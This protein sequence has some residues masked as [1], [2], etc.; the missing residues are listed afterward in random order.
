[1]PIEDEKLYEE[2]GRTWRHFA[3]WREKAFAGYLTALAALAIGFSHNRS[4]PVRAGVFA[5]AILVSTV[6]W[7]IDFRNL[8]LMHACQRAAGPLERE[9]GWYAELNRVRDRKS[10]LTHGLAINLLVV[11][12]GVASVL[13]ISICIFRWWSDGS[14]VWPSWPFLVLLVVGVGVLAI[15][16]HLH[17]KELAEKERSLD[18]LQY[19]TSKAEKDR[20]LY[21]VGGAC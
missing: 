15:C 8:Q 16:V 18:E 14:M 5:G 13:G 12:V 2:I 10:F 7:I 17:L 20:A 11:G 4:L 3:S 19:R 1:M 21:L 6:F 9:K